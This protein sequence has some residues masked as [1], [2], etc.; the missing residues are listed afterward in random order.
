MPLPKY[1][2]PECYPDDV[3]C[4]KTVAAN[5]DAYRLVDTIPPTSADFK[6]YKEDCPHHNLPKD[7][8]KYA[9]GVSFWATLEAAKEV[10][11]RYPRA[12]QF[13]RKKIAL[14]D[15]KQ[16]LGVIAIDQPRENHISLWKQEGYC[17]S[18]CFKKEEV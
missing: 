15:F 2:W 10:K 1:N 12:N 9:F 16:E 3:S 14:I 7:Q 11:R 18:E 8:K 17:P 13:G 5:G 4:G 6:M